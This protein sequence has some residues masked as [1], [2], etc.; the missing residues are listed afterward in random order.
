MRK[1]V[2]PVDKAVRII[3][4]A[5]VLSLLFIIEG[6]ARFLGLFG[7]IP[8]VVAFVGYCPLYPLVGLDTNRK[9]KG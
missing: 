5:A 3:G 8:I 6:N 9:N 4:G 7:I 1:N 2:G